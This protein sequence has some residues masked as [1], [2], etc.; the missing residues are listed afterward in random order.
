VLGW[1][2]IL[3]LLCSD[4]NA[5]HPSQPADVTLARRQ[6]VLSLSVQCLLGWF[7]S[8]WSS[9]A[10]WPLPRP[11]TRAPQH[12][13]SSLVGSSPGA[14]SATWTE[15]VAWSSGSRVL[16]GDSGTSRFVAA[17]YL[18]RKLKRCCWRLPG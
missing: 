7:T 13:P 11:A 2:A 15:S 10:R 16:G 5:L 18:M 3:R 6:Q 8:T 1:L 9:P 17:A 12:H 14:S 4:L